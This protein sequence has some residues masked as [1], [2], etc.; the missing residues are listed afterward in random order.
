MTYDE[1]KSTDTTDQG[2][3]PRPEG[4]DEVPLDGVVLHDIDGSHIALPAAIAARL[5][6]AV[7]AQDVEQILREE[8]TALALICPRLQSLLREPSLYLWCDQA[9]DLF[10]D[11]LR[12][13]GL[14]HECVVGFCDEGSSHAWVRVN[15]LNLDPT[16]QGFGA[17]KFEVYSRYD[18]DAVA[19]AS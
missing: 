19:E 1:W 16:D 5:A 17:G 2:E 14:A 18:P 15:G 12:W 10:S 3:P 6:G 8:E 13:K 4:A 9:A 7:T 11:V